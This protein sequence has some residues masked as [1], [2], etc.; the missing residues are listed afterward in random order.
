SNA[1]MS[2]LPNISAG[3]RGFATDFDIWSK[4][5]NN[6]D[7]TVASV[8]FSRIGS[9]LDAA[10]KFKYDPSHMDGISKALNSI[11]TPLGNAAA[12]TGITEAG[13]AF[14]R[15]GSLL[16]AVTKINPLQLDGVMTSLRG[17]LTHMG[18]S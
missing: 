14:G 6:A 17:L 2:R 8:A 9:F 13:I 11:L 1:R 3:L 12:I 5:L 10:R 18:A 7:V 4:T 16:N 15:M